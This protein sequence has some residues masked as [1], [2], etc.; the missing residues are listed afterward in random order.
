MIEPAFEELA[1]T[2]SRADGGVGFAK[3]DLSVGLGGALANEYQV[4]VTPTFLFF[5]DGS[6]VR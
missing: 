5:L 3:I 4:R 6:K 1:K 2:K